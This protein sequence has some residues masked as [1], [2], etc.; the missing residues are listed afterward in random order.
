MPYAV[1]DLITAS[2]L[3][4]ITDM[5]RAYWG[6]GGSQWGLGQDITLIPDV[7]PGDTETAAQRN[8]IVTTLNK[9]L[10]HQGQADITP[11]TVAVGEAIRSLTSVANATNL[12]YSNT[13]LTSQPLYT[14]STTTGITTDHW[15]D[16]GNKTLT[17]THTVTFSSA[18]A[19]RYFFNAGGRI[20]IQTTKTGGTTARD[21]S[22]TTLSNAIGPFTYQFHEYWTSTTTNSILASQ[23]A[24]APYSTNKISILARLSGTLSNGGRPTIVF[25]T[26]WENLSATDTLGVNGTSGA[27]ISVKAPNTPH[28]TDTWGIPIT[29]SSW[30]AGGV[31][32]STYCEGFSLKKTYQDGAGGILIETPE[33]Y[34]LSC[35]GIA[36]G[37]ELSSYCSSTTLVGRYADGAGG[38][39]DAVK[40]AYS[41]SCGGIAAGTE[42]STFC[43]ATTLMGRYADG[44]G[45]TYDTV[46]QVKSLSCGYQVPHGYQTFISA[47]TFSFTVPAEVTSLTIIL[48]GGGGGGGGRTGMIAVNSNYQWVGGGGGGSGGSIV[49][50]LLTVSPNDILTINVGTGGI[51]GYNNPNANSSGGNGTSGGNSSVYAGA[52]Q[53]AIAPGGSF[54]YGAYGAGS[55]GYPYG[56]WG[57]S[58]PAGSGTYPGQPGGRGDYWGVGPSG[59]SPQSGYAVAG[60][61]VGATGVTGTQGF[62]NRIGG[63]GGGLTTNPAW[64]AYLLSILPAFGLGGRGSSFD[65]LNGMIYVSW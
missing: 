62:L 59:Q 8:G 37:T 9:A 41:L 28:L 50:Q 33:P 5:L 11:A 57:A 64:P 4:T 19:A 43:S 63:G 58:G 10:L 13:G 46:K 20:V 29:A 36:A 47:G 48:L 2:G 61:G 27:S 40:Q 22:W 12:V 21:T 34:S 17:T 1:D 30:L 7:S 60:Q 26:A 45:G 25:T 56:L 16:R 14:T 32:L 52:T 31:L 23:N 65:G 18:N 53:I 55:G 3:D 54:G 51:A 44:A 6:I 42:L 39:Y 24:A 35:G 49:E 15:G 38:T